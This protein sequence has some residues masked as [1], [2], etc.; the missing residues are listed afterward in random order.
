MLVTCVVMKSS[1]VS[2]SSLP[3]LPGLEAIAI[4][5][6]GLPVLIRR[7]SAAAGIAAKSPI[8]NNIARER[9][10]NMFSS[11]CNLCLVCCPE[12]R[13]NNN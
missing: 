9:L 12:T 11:F 7:L 3:G 13:S 4:N 10:R 6:S 8:A 5:P 2:V 1:A